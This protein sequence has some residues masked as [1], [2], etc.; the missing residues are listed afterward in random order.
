MHTFSQDS[1]ILFP[2]SEQILGL[3]GVAPEQL[4]EIKDAEYVDNSCNPGQ[5][6]GSPGIFAFPAIVQFVAFEEH[7]SKSQPSGNLFAKNSSGQIFG[8][9][10]QLKDPLK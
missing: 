3:I 7:F 1:Q 2:Q 10:G 5:H 4:F 9:N 6:L 8:I